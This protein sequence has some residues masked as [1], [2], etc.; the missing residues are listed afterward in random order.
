MPIANK[1]DFRDKVLRCPFCLE[2]VGTP[3]PVKTPF[4]STMDGGKCVCGGVFVYDR[5][6]RL[7]GEAFSDALA[8]AFDWDY[9]AAFTTEVGYEEA[10]VIYNTSVGKYLLIETVQLDRTPKYYFV[11]RLKQE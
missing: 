1:K 4:G 6:G 9:D 7:L 10:M 5:T 2:P 8:Y 11:K 3:A